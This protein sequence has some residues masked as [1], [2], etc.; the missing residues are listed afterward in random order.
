MERKY[1][2]KLSPKRKNTIT[3]GKFLLVMET[4]S[5]LG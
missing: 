1:L 2:E 5:K 4:L 3:T